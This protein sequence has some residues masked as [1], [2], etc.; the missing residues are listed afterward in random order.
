MLVEMPMVCQRHLLLTVLPAIINLDTDSPAI[1]YHSL[2]Y[3]FGI[4]EEMI[5]LKSL[6]WGQCDLMWVW[7]HTAWQSADTLKQKD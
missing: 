3:C 4:I 7:C 2:F 1:F 5:E 6:K